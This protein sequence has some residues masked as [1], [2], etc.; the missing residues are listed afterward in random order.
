ML[1]LLIGLQ[2]L[3]LEIRGMEIA[4]T[5]LLQG[6]CHIGVSHS[7]CLGAPFWQ[8]VISAAVSDE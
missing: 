6:S 3:L 4:S 5:E 7:G 8:P 2:Y 1:C